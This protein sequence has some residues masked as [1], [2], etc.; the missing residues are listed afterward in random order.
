VGLKKA[1]VMALVAAGALALPGSAG[2]AGNGAGVSCQ[3]TP[4]GTVF[5]SPGE[6]FR[7]AR[8]AFGF[9]PTVLASTFGYSSPGEMVQAVC[10]PGGTDS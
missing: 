4:N 7:D 3:V 2:A 9:S 6:M 1:T 10:T 8:D 5:S